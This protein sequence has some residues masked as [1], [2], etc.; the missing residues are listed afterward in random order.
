M[1]TKIKLGAE[2]RVLVALCNRVGATVLYEYCPEYWYSNRLASIPAASPVPSVWYKYRYSN[3][4][5]KWYKICFQRDRQ[6]NSYN[7]GKQTTPTPPLLIIIHSKARIP[8]H[9]CLLRSSTVSYVCPTLPLSPL[10]ASARVLTPTHPPYRATDL[11]HF[12]QV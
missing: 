2:R 1:L 8:P 4:V 3:K 12:A 10:Q 7:V 11:L 6:P 9:L 5:T